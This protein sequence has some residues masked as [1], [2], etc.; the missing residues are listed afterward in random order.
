MTTSES[1][2]SGRYHHGD[3][4]AALLDSALEVLEETGVMGFSIR[5]AARRCG[6]SQSAPK[7]HFGDARGLLGALARRAFEE[8]CVRLEAVDLTGLEARVRVATLAAEYVCFAQQNRA[9]FDLMWRVTQ[10]DV[11]DPALLEPKRR[12]LHA[13][14]RGVRGPDVDPPAEESALLPSYAIW[15]LVHG[16]AT[17][18]LEGA[19]DHDSTEPDAG[20]LLSAM[21]ALIDLDPEGSG[22]DDSG[23]LRSSH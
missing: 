14:D 5:E 10:F 15:S 13:L 18:A 16:Y 20:G 12:A 17:L 1:R 21:L 2:Q 22:T 4:R 23:V 9:L 3:L 11:D 19:M 6:V 7:Y 8:L